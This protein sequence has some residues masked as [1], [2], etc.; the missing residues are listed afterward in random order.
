MIALKKKVNLKNFDFVV[1]SSASCVANFISVYKNIPPHLKIITKGKPT[2]K[3]IKELGLKVFN[4]EQ[5][6]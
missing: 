6:I 2:E 5:S 1:F 3:K 4:Y